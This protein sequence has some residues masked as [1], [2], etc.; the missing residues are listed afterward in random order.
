MLAVAVLPCHIFP[1][2]VQLDGCTGV[3][4]RVPVLV[5]GLGSAMPPNIGVFP[6]LANDAD[7]AIVY[8][9]KVEEHPPTTPPFILFSCS[10]FHLHKTQHPLLARTGRSSKRRRGRRLISRCRRLSVWSPISP[11]HSLTTYLPTY[12]PTYSPPSTTKAKQV[13]SLPY[14]TLPYL[15]LDCGRCTHRRARPDIL[16]H[17]AVDVPYCS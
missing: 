3:P 5:P 11:A 9:T 6:G 7:I 4:V 1:R 17:T 12:L 8:C 16:A 15:A 10:W 2:E 13:G 14:I